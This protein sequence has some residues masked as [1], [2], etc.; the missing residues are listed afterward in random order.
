MYSSHNWGKSVSA[1]RFIKTLK[2][3]ILKQKTANDKKFYL[4]YLTKL[5][6]RYSNTYHYSDNKNLLM[7]IIL[8]WLKTTEASSK[9]HKFEVNDRVWNKKYE[10]FLVKVSLRTGQGR[11]LLL[12]IF[13]KLVLG[14][15]E[16]KFWTEK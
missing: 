12:I 11:Y 5:V 9:A 7:Q 10:I 1:E 15:I 8:F 3:K 4:A 16:L 14:V 2:A 13:W 6:D